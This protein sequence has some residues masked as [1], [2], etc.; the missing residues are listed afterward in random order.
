[1]PTLR[2]RPVRRPRRARCCDAC[3]RLIAG[4]HVYLYGSA[5]VGDKP[6]ALRPHVACCG[7]SRE[8]KIIE[9]LGR[10]LPS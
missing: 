6:S 10:L 7:D 9:A 5:D 4:P 1:M 3:G 2:A 8:P